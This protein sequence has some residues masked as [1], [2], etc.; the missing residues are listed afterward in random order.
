[1]PSQELEAIIQELRAGPR[2]ADYASA[3]VTPP[4]SVPSGRPVL[5]HARQRF[6]PGRNLGTARPCFRRPVKS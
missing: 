5:P 3:W 6:R 4:P 1:M 2:L